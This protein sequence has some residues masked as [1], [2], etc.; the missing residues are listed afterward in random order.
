MCNQ[1]LRDT[2][3]Y[4]VLKQGLIKRFR[5]RNTSW[6]YRGRLS[7]VKHRPNESLEAFV[8]RIRQL[9]KN[10]Y[11]LTTSEET[12]RVLLQEAEHRA[13]DVFFVGCSRS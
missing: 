13:L 5:G 3:D 12:N 2:Q 7:S 1:E 6:Y 4:E 10:T 8:D 9:N 11:E